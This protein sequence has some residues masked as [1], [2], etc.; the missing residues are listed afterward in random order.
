MHPSA[1]LKSALLLTPRLTRAGLRAYSRIG[2]SAPDS[3]LWILEDLKRELAPSGRSTVRLRSSN[4]SIRVDANTTIGREVYYSGS[5]DFEL[6][7]LLNR[8][9]RPGMVVFDAGA[10]IG[11]FAIRASVLVGPQGSVHAFEAAPVTFSHLVENIALNSLANVTAS[12]VIICDELDPK[13]FYLSRGSD[14]GS[15]SL[16]PA[17]DFSGTTVE[18]QATT[19]DAYAADHGVSHVDLLKLDIEGAELRALRGA[20]GLLSGPHPPIIVTEYHSQVAARAGVDLN[21]TTRFLTSYGYSV[22]KMGK[23]ANQLD[24]DTTHGEV[25]NVLALPESAKGL[26]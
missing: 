9:L 1:V 4:C 11:E 14:S 12:Q 16:V 15:S 2:V 7:A 23:S 22:R 6:A 10:N 26:A 3:L 8:T 17:H 13:T 25:F 21:E 19:L 18:V 24:L 20:T 5:Y